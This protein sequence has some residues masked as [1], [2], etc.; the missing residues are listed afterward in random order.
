MLVLLA[1][2]W[3]TYFIF[4]RDEYATGHPLYFHAPDLTQNPLAVAPNLLV[5]PLVNTQ[6]DQ[7]LL[8]SGLLLLFGTAVER[9]LGTAAA[10]A[11]FWVASSTAAVLGGLLLHPLYSHFPDVHMFA[12]GGWYRI[13]NGGSAGGFA[14]L[15]AYAALSPRPWLWVGLFLVWEPVFWLFVSG[16]FTSV[17]HFIAFVTGFLGARWLQAQSPPQASGSTMRNSLP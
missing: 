2:S 8:V 9:R 5:T 4:D 10:L 14:L 1:L 17:F 6:T 13:F 3:V 15:A 12:D 16:D 7:I 11:L